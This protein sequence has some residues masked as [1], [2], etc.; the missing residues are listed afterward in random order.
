MGGDEAVASCSG[1]VLPGSD[2]FDSAVLGAGCER[3]PLL[4]FPE[5]LSETKLPDGSRKRLNPVTTPRY[6]IAW[7]WRGAAP[8]RDTGP[9][10]ARDGEIQITRPR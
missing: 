1:S 5:E 3:L 8:G 9:E 4:A 10:E 2:R 7:H 6:M